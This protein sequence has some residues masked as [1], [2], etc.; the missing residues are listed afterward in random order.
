MTKAIITAALALSLAATPAA[1]QANI[2]GRWTN[3]KHTTLSSKNCGQVACVMDFHF[4]GWFRL[5][6]DERREL[7]RQRTFAENTVGMGHN[8]P[9][10]Q[11]HHGKA[12]KQCMQLR[13]QHGCRYP[14]P[15]NITKHEEQLSV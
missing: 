7:P 5:S 6:A 12:T 1:A 14:F 2:E 4:A 3:P 11:G 10:R 9:K 8:L 15:G 13:H